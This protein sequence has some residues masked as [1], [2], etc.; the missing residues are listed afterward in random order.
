MQSPTQRELACMQV[1][2]IPEL[3][4][5][6]CKS[7]RKSDNVSLLRVSRQLFHDIRPFVWES[8][9]A[10]ATLALMIPGTNIVVHDE[11][12]MPFTVSS[13]DPS[14]KYLFSDVDT[15]SKVMH[16]PGS[17][18]LSRFNLYAPYIK[19]LEIPYTLQ[20]D[21]YD[22]WEDFLACTRSIDLLPNLETLHMVFSHPWTECIATDLINWATAFL[23]T[24]LLGLSVHPDLLRPMFASLWMNSPRSTHFGAYVDLNLTHKLLRHVS[25]KC[26]QLNSL[27]LMPGNVTTKTTTEAWRGWHSTSQVLLTNVS[28]T[29]PSSL[30]ET[31]SNILRFRSLRTLTT[32]PFILEAQTFMALS[33]LPRLQSLSVSSLPEDLDIYCRGFEVPDNAFPA[34]QSLELKCMNWDSII[35]LCSLKPFIHDLRSVNILDARSLVGTLNRNRLAEL[36]SLFAKHNSPI[37]SMSVQGHDSW[38][39]PPGMIQYLQ[40]LPLVKLTLAPFQLDEFNIV[41]FLHALPVVEELR[42]ALPNALHLGQLRLIVSLLSKLHSLSLPFLD[43]SVDELSE[44]DFRILRSQSQDKLYLWDFPLQSLRD[45]DAKRLA[46]YKPTTRNCRLQELIAFRLLDISMHCD[47]T[48]SAKVPG[49]MAG[50]QKITS[51]LITT[52]QS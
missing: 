39:T 22:N 12:L 26:P 29:T 18:D 27:T 8:T 24:S 3:A 35:N 40:Y 41:T 6:I 30:P 16:L 15:T 7:A 45:E 13:Y 17:L 52:C 48:L 2:S 9:D 25:P 34:L 28:F 31:H 4:H 51:R 43:E 11:D 14:C 32:T 20:I 37:T 50:G 19:Q 36:L 10:I 42:L 5:L 47:Q 46:R 38:P 1:F 33:Q 49:T 21:K 23:S 44:E